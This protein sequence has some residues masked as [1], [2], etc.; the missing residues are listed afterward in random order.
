MKKLLVIILTMLVC[1]SLLANKS[2]PIFE[3]SPTAIISGVT[4][5]NREAWDVLFTF[6]CSAPF[7]SGIEIDNVNIYTTSFNAGNFSRYEMDGTLISD[8]TISGVTNIRDM[9]YD[10]TYFYG[11][12]ASMTI[13]IMDLANETLIGIIPVT[14]AGITGVRHIAF[15]PGLDD[16]NGGFWVGNWDEFGAIAMDGSQIY[17]SIADISESTYG[18]AYDPWTDGGPYIWNFKQIGSGAELHQF[19]IASQTLTGVVHDASDIPGFNAGIAGGLA[20]YV[21]DNG[22][23][24]MLANIQQ[25]TNIVGIYEIAITSDPEAPGAATDVVVTPDVGGALEAVIDW[26]CPDI[27]VAGDPLTELD[28][29]LVYRGEDLIYTDTEPVIGEAG[30]YTDADISASDN[31]TYKVIG[32]N[33]EG[34]GLSV[35]VTVWVGEDVPNIVTDLLLEEQDGNGYL[36]WVNPTTGLNGGP[37]NEAITGYHIERNDGTML[38]INE[39]ATEFIDELISEA[40]HYTYN[41][42]AYNSVGDGGS[43]TSNIALI[44]AGTEI[45]FD[46]FET[47][48]GNWDSITNGGGEWLIYAPQYPNNYQ[49]PPSSAGNVCSADSYETG[50]GNCTIELLTVL[51]LSSFSTVNIR[52]DNDFNSVSE[53]D[54]GYV[55]VSN[56]GGSNWENVHVFTGV[57]VT[58]THEIVDITAFA[59]GQS[60]VLIRFNSVQPGWDWWWTIDNVGVYGIGGF[61]EGTVTLD[62]G[63]GNI[64][65]VEVTFDDVT[66]NPSASGDYVIPL[67]E[68]TYYDVSAEL[69]GYDLAT[70][71]SVIVTE[72]IITTDMDFTLIYNPPDFNPV[73]N[74][75]VDEL[76]GLLTWETPRGFYEDFEGTFPPDGWIKLNPVIG[77]GWEP[78]EVGTTPLPGWNGGEATACP[79]GGEWQAYCSYST[80]GA[81]SNDQWLITPQITVHSDD[82]LNFY[83]VYYQNS[84]AD[85]VEILISTTVQNDPA[86]F[87][88]I[89]DII[90]F[91]VGDST[92]WREYSYNLT[93][94]VSAGTDIFIGFRENVEDNGI[95]GSAIALDNVHV[96]QPIQSVV[97]KSI[98][99][100]TLQK[101]TSVE[102]IVNYVHIPNVH[103]VETRGL[104]GYN[105]YLDGVF[106][107]NITDLEYQLIDLV[108]GTDYTAGVEA[109][110][111]DGLS[112]IVEITFT[113]GVS[114]TEDIIGVDTKLNGNYPNPFNP[115]TN[116]AYSIRDAGNVTL[117]V[118]NLRG[119]LVKTLINEVKETGNHTAFWNGTNNS[120]KSVSSGIYFYKMKSGNYSSTKKMI[121]MK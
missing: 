29:M 68:G 38:E 58:A 28:S 88:T 15:D 111:D 1:I 116:I 67:L 35:L 76:S 51:D 34:E 95:N 112:A 41:I 57:D 25:G 52:F 94:F 48:L 30:T 13:Y 27:D 80:G 11:S 45:F 49:M 102:R 75:A 23:F 114:E 113:Y 32:F 24:A 10:G 17:A 108:D 19:D 12:P 86:A 43:A 9:A 31:Y 71:D 56:D 74:L 85:H 81:T 92:I 46:D 53:N 87:D 96:V 89:V 63:T 82:M 118:Y 18:T 61:V 78:L 44:G 109:V 47:G 99:P 93:D 117:R 50:S 59:A 106:Q 22:I 26:V 21:N 110:Y 65:D 119:Q 101:E 72:G 55:D 121:L 64:E 115:I 107:D 98:E 62:G 14:C 90:D 104:T 84:Y 42:T 20:T 3:L 5:S 40:D 69:V 73:E 4:A 70:I 16:G 36:T 105:I 37:F 54:Y 60:D 6:D 39:L 120:N 91:S 77:S 97:M 100:I 79:D 33:T 66:T 103:I 7:H 8:F 83:M 2:T